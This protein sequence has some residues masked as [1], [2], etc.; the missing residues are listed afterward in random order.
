MNLGQLIP[1][2]WAQEGCPRRFPLVRPEGAL[3][4]G[5]SLVHS[6]DRLV[7]IAEAR[8]SPKGAHIPSRT[9]KLRILALLD[10]KAPKRLQS[11]EIADAL[12]DGGDINHVCAV[13]PSLIAD[14]YVDR[15]GAP[16]HYA[17]GLT[18]W[19][20]KHLLASAVA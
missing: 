7:H 11:R 3:P 16:K 14:S 10:A 9:L 1:P 8:P 6:A 18:P 5:G 4:S 2:E 13:L 17:Y 15:L 19:G 12:G 20:A